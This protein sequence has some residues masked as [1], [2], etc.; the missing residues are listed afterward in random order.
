[1][2]EQDMAKYSIVV[3]RRRAIPAVQDG[4]KPVQRRSIFAAF[5]DRLTKPLLK[6]KSASLVGTTMKYY[7]P[8]GDSSIYE[9]IVTLVNWFK[10][11]YPLFYGKGNWGSCAGAS[12][13]VLG[14]SA[15]G[16]DI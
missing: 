8:H 6:D 9:T 7:H 2:Y 13:A 5:R 16:W 11:K 1:M 15:I 4:L 12:A 10:T 3:N 14:A